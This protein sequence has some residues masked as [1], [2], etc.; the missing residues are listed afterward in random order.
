MSQANELRH[1][2]NWLR[3]L[4]Q[5]CA[6]GKDP[7]NREKIATYAQ[8]LQSDDDFPLEAFTSDS[9]KAIA[10]ASEFFPS[11]SMLHKLLTEWWHAHR[12]PPVW[13]LLDGPTVEG[14]DEI[15]RHMVVAFQRNREENV[16]GGRLGNS[17]S[18][19]RAKFPQAFRY[20]L[21]IDAEAHDI[22]VRR[23]WRDEGS[24][25]VSWDDPAAIRSSVR[26]V[27]SSPVQQLFLGR[28]LGKLV[29]IHAPRHLHHVPPAWHPV[30]TE[31]A[32]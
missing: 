21:S 13:Q 12:P 16:R 30:E 22:A 5:L 18:H 10:K 15:N 2:A 27:L 29:S 3:Q 23:G 8:F 14:M 31:E 20:V 28:L 9:L 17:L 6:P 26:E 25:G 4:A 19:L 24:A 32:A 11:L 1:I 7:V